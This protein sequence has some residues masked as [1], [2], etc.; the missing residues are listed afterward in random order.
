MDDLFFS[1][2]VGFEVCA[3][4]IPLGSKRD[5]TESGNVA[6]VDM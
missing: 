2:D 5:V 4:G 1:M 6:L 3:E